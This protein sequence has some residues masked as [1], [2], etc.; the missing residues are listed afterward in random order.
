MIDAFFIFSILFD[1]HVIILEGL[2]YSDA[3]IPKIALFAIL[4]ALNLFLQVLWHVPKVAGTVRARLALVIWIIMLAEILA[5]LAVD[6]NSTR[7][8]EGVT[9]VVILVYLTYVMLPMTLQIC[10]LLSSAASVVYVCVILVMWL[11]KES[12]TTLIGNQV[13]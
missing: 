8:S 4:L 12:R 7:P 10:L 9:W 13:S 2:R 11:Q 1:A 6:S 3:K 5:E